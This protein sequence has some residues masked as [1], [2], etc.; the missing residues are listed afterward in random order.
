MKT[1]ISS[2]ALTAAVLLAASAVG[3]SSAGFR[4]HDEQRE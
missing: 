3:R 2:L 4:E 1:R